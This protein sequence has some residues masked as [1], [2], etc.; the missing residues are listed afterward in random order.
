MIK[1][2]AGARFNYLIADTYMGIENMELEELR[3]MVE[4]TA[5]IQLII[6]SLEQSE[7][8]IVR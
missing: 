7:R 6:D 5:E 3:A 1:N 8:G 2:L 4:E